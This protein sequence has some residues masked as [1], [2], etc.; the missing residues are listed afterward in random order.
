M[1][2]KLTEEELDALDSALDLVLVNMGA[3][4]DF[5][6]H[7]RGIDIASL[8][9]VHERIVQRKQYRLREGK[10]RVIFDQRLRENRED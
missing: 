7:F 8:A 6:A 2:F 4:A 10:S 1:H 5:D 9:T 3:S